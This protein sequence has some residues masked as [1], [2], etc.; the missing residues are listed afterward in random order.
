MDSLERNNPQQD[1]DVNVNVKLI[2]MILWILWV[3]CLFLR[4]DYDDYAAEY[5]SKYNVPRSTV[6][7][8]VKTNP[9]IFPIPYTEYVVRYENGTDKNVGYGIL[10]K[11]IITDRIGN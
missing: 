2:V 7:S 5:A 6:L 4:P 3:A 9:H 8:Y 1:A 10:G 11:I